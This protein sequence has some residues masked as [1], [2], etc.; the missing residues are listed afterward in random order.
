MNTTFDPKKYGNNKLERQINKVYA[1]FGIRLEECSNQYL[2]IKRVDAPINEHP[3]PGYKLLLI[4][5]SSCKM[6]NTK[7]GRKLL[8]EPVNSDKKFWIHDYLAMEVFNC[9]GSLIGYLISTKNPELIELSE[10]YDDVCPAIGAASSDYR[11]RKN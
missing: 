9:V 8:V 4:A 10:G 2:Q 3:I 6:V 11:F 5:P 1:Y 7:Y